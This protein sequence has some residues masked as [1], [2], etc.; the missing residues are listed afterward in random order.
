MDVIRVR[1]SKGRIRRNH[2]FK[3][4]KFPAGYPF[5]DSD[6]AKWIEAASLSHKTR[7]DRKNMARIRNLIRGFSG[8]QRRDGYMNSWFEVLHPDKRWTNLRDNHEL[9]C[10]GHMIEAAVAYHQATG[11]P[12]LLKMLCKYA[13][14][15]DETFGR[16]RGQKRGYGGHPE[17]ELALV[18]LYR[19][20]G[21]KRYLNLARYFIDERGRKPFYFE[22]EVKKRLRPGATF[23]S[24]D[25]TYHQAHAPVRHQDTAEGHAVRACYLYAGMA[26]VAAETGDKT[27]VRACKKLWNNIVQRRMYVT[28]GIGSTHRG[29]RFTFD[30]DLPSESAYAETCASIALAFFSHRLFHLD[31]DG[32]YMDVVER[33]LYNGILSGVSLDGQKFFYHNPL[34][35]QP[36][37]NLFEGYFPPERQGWFTTPCCPSNLSRILAE[38]GSYVYSQGSKNI[39]V[40]LYASNHAQLEVSGVSVFIEQKTEYPW[41]EKTVLRISPDKPVSFS[42]ALRLPGWCQR[43]QVMVNGQSQNLAKISRKGYA[44]LRRKW[45][46]GDTVELRL[47]MP[48]VVQEADPR[49]RQLQGQKALTRGPLVYC[50]EE[51]DNGKDL[52]NLYLPRKPVFHIRHDPKLLAGVTVLSAKVLRR[53]THTGQN[54]LYGSQVS[55]QKAFRLKAVPYFAWANRGIGEMRVWISSR[56]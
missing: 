27:L 30:Y 56:S 48:V 24:Q 11:D 17:I 46:A 9:Y 41:K 4:G 34:S 14:H 10:A 44:Y 26:D 36:R 39:Y 5:N 45:K 12:A 15:I 25:R 38:L 21:Q 35:Q 42:L 19:E 16:K 6:I 18:K 33:V 49:V 32:R 7:P 31:R 22:M 53:Q 23:R 51:K 1:D 37:A 8:I 13:D 47:P 43:P 28:G 20:T 50:L 29:E 54:E 3:T 2:P 40:H 52:A 55:S